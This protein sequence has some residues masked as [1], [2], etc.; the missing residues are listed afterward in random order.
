MTDSPKILIVNHDIPELER[1]AETLVNGGFTVAKA[2]NGPEA[3]ALTKAFVP[4]LMLLD[5]HIA[6]GQLKNLLERIKLDRDLTQPSIIML[7]TRET[8]SKYQSRL[9]EMGAAGTLVGSLP[10]SE[11]LARVRVYARQADIF[12][13]LQV[14]EQRLRDLIYDLI[15]ATIIVDARGTIQFVNAE[16]EAVLEQYSKDRLG[17]PFTLAPLHAGTQ[18][19]VVQCLHNDVA[20]LEIRIASTKWSDDKGWIVSI[21][22]VTQRR[23]TEARVLALNRIYAFLSQINSTII[24]VRER[25]ALYKATCD[26]AVGIGGFITSWIGVCTDHDRSLQIVAF[27]SQQGYERKL[28]PTVVSHVSEALGPFALAIRTGQASICNNTS[29][30]TRFGTWCALARDQGCRSAAAF[31]LRIDG[32]VFA[33]I[34]FYSDKTDYFDS[35]EI[36]LLNELAA[37]IS[38][39][40]EFIEAEHRQRQSELKIRDSESRF[41]AVFEQ[42]TSGICIMSLNHRFEQVNA[43]F[44][45][46]LGY[47]ESE[48][49]SMYD[50]RLLTHS[51]DRI[52]DTTAIA[53]VLETGKGVVLEKRC[54]RKDASIVWVRLRLSILRSEDGTPKHFVGL[55]ADIT[56]EQSALDKVQQAQSLIRM[57]SKLSRLGA[58][59]VDL[60]DSSVALSDELREILEIPTTYMPT[61]KQTLE[62][63]T[64]ESREAMTSAFYAC[65]KQGVPYDLEFDILTGSGRTIRG[66]SIAEAV[67]DP[68]GKIIKV[69]GAFQDVSERW[70]INYALIESLRR[71]RD[72]ADSMPMM[73]WSATVDGRLEFITRAFES[74]AGVPI[75][76]DYGPIFL[77]VL[78]PDDQLRCSDA[79]TEMMNAQ[80][81]ATLE[82]RLRRRDGVYRWHLGRASPVRD[83]AGRVIK[84]YGSATDIHDLKMLESQSQQL[85]ERLTTTFESITDAFVMLD[86]NWKYV[87]LNAQAEA[88][89][90]KPR[91]RLIGK[92]I[93]K[94]L[95]FLA[96]SR[97]EQELRRAV[98]GNTP[99][100]FEDHYSISNAWI[101]CHAYPSP[102][103]LSIYFRE[104]T[105]QRA[106]NAQLRLL[107]ASVARLNDIILITEAEPIDGEGPRIVFVNDAFERRTGYRREEVLGKTPRILQGA[108]TD[109]RALDRIR[110]A[111]KQWQPV[112]EELLNYTKSGQPFWI[113]LDIVP[114]ADEKGWYTH[115]VAVERD[116]TE[117]R[118]LE[119]QLRQSQ[120]LESIGH[121]T[122]GLAH[123]FNNLLTIIMGN[124]ELLTE[125]LKSDPKLNEL[126]E[127]I[128]TAASR[129]SDLTQGLLSF[130]RRQ[131]LNPKPTDIAQLVIGMDGL[132]RRTLG[133]Q[134]HFHH[135]GAVSQNYALVDHV[136]LESAILNL[137]INSRD[138]MPG[139]GALTIETTISVL[140]QVDASK[141]ADAQ[142]GRYVV[143]A[144]SD[145][146]HGIS[147]ENLPRIFEPFFTTKETGKG[148]G[149]GL[150][151][152]YGFV[153]QSRGHI[154]VHSNS[155]EGT[156]F[157]LYLPA[158]ELVD[159]DADNSSGSNKDASGLATILLVE[160]NELVRRYAYEQLIS[161]GYTVLQAAEAVAAVDLLK[162]HPE[163][164][165]LF[166][167]VVM[168]G[169][170][171]GSQLADFARELRPTIRILFTSGYAEKDIVH[172]GR[173][174]SGIQLL[175]KPYRHSDLAR[176]IRQVL[177]TDS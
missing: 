125:K 37:D 99:V 138:A 11:F 81:P 60:S 39:S 104:V 161:L 54:I 177:S 27:A 118:N 164:D 34:V 16:A 102:D 158:C 21:R 155:G 135:V 159:S 62:A 40:L 101:E 41:R 146:G 140:D 150:S 141:H 126:A 110:N 116:V 129:G 165:L 175:S 53:H 108:D 100:E 156:T 51:D 122:G 144:V 31:P 59:S 172:Q 94:T 80:V 98:D 19:V 29:N 1:L 106:A 128:L 88:L 57:A 137:C 52:A 2:S 97:L 32:K 83:A 73:V 113:E 35:Q 121:L 77:S 152:V 85:A 136:Q 24:H 169:P 93:W 103:G 50:S 56:E 142:A 105:H 151:M 75:H 42:V 95:P 117:R 78:H 149:L 154:D 69:Q 5:V 15:D 38:F 7:T 109:R 84:W 9:L 66:R 168:P 145:T 143:V 26:I 153:R 91:E 33:A 166:T 47:S 48:L 61:L 167:D 174:D 86:R 148:T 173:L 13:A 14:N 4:S 139:G 157:K 132:L 89:I 8:E 23:R 63:Y 130:A 160:D 131:P 162:M 46:I 49:A 134:I 44:C 127:M 82:Y 171:S 43:R 87:Y 123:D 76:G 170:M 115:W 124:A 71:F 20:E 58:W 92:T 147:P 107:E 65:A 3:W 72:L 111:L 96:G 12:R 163:I 64:E 36:K 114:I 67:R 30:D 70:R 120:R 119:N 25:P 18:E 90:Q 10:D 17:A 74:Y 176:T 133:E 68:S 55:I 6:R 22:D 112:R 45:E 79:W 28:I